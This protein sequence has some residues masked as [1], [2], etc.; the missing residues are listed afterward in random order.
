MQARCE[1][2][3]EPPELREEPPLPLELLLELMDEMEDAERPELR[4]ELTTAAMRH[5]ALQAGF[6]SVLYTQAIMSTQS[7]SPK[8]GSPSAHLPATHSPLATKQSP[9]AKHARDCRG[10]C[11]HMPPLSQSSPRSM[12]PLP[13]RAMREELLLPEAGD[14]ELPDLPDD[15][16]DDADSER[17]ELEA[18]AH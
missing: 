4:E 8:H 7:Q 14:A 17:A 9:L 12:R 2:V 10:P 5:C 15:E 13:Q 1:T 3:T 18:M 11:S 16:S 6:L